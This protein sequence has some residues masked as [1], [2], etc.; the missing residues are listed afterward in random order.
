MLSY[1]IMTKL[2]EMDEKIKIKDQLEE[3]MDGQVILI[4]K[5]NVTSDKIEQFLKFGRKMLT[6]LYNNLN[7]FLQ[8]YIRTLARVLYS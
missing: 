4:N 5:F 8:N 2:V 7:L 3:E 1:I 6:A